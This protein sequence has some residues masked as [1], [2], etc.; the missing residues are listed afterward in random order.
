[1]PTVMEAFLQNMNKY[2]TKVLVNDILF[3]CM[4]IK[5]L[6]LKKKCFP[7]CLDRSYGTQQKI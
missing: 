1:M 5:K 4:H 3:S 6:S 7:Y 2:D